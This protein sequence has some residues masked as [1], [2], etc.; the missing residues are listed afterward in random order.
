MRTAGLH[1]GVL[2]LLE[3]LEQLLLHHG[4]PVFSD[5]GHAVRL[6]NLARAMQGFAEVCCGLPE[7]LKHRVPRLDPG[8]RYR[9]RVQARIHF[10]HNPIKPRRS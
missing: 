10:L 7:G 5:P 3:S 6:S 8:L 2:C 1:R 9:A 4:S